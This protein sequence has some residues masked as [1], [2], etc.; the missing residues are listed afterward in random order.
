MEFKSIYAC[1]QLVQVLNKSQLV[2][3]WMVHQCQQ[4]HQTYE[5]RFS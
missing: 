4:T 2:E 5:I 3:L 1:E